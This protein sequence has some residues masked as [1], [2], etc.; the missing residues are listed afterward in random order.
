MF[1]GLEKQ[2]YLSNN[3]PSDAT[4]LDI[5]L[6]CCKQIIQMWLDKQKKYPS[7]ND[8]NEYEFYAETTFLLKKI[9]QNISK[10]YVMIKAI[11]WL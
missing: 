9:E 7:L 2:I 4:F 11:Y 1:M 3:R 10:V 5:H 6:D 8:P